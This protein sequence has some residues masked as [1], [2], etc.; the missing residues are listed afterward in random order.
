[1]TQPATT[2]AGAEEGAREKRKGINGEQ[3]NS[4]NQ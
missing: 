4:N 2:T 1:M 3:K